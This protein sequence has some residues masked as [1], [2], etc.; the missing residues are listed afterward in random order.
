MLQGEPTVRS[1]LRTATIPFGFGSALSLPIIVLK[2]DGPTGSTRSSYSA[3]PI[4]V[5]D[6]ITLS[7]KSILVE[8]ISS[9][10]DR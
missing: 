5:K 7:N 10:S 6:L 9:G 3:G 2:L 8:S 1:Q 4:P